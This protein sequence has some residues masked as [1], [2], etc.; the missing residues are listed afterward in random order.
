[1]MDA[2]IDSCVKRKHQ[3]RDQ[4]SRG[5]DHEES[6]RDGPKRQYRN[7]KVVNVFWGV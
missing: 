4:R 2:L 7:G 3:K 6:V 5:K 1:M